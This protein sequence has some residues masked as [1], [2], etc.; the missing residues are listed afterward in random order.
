MVSLSKTFHV[1][2]EEDFSLDPGQPVSLASC[3]LFADREDKF[4]MLRMQSMTT[5]L[6]VSVTVSVIFFIFRLRYSHS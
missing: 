2:F 6:S 4:H 5:V 3:Q 1:H